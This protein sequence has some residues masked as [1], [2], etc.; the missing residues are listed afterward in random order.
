MLV[1][2]LD[3]VPVFYVLLD[4]ARA[5]LDLTRSVLEL[6]V[7]EHERKATKISLKLL[8]PDFT[9]RARLEHGVQ[10]TVRWGYV[11]ALSAPRAGI[12]HKAEPSYDEGV[13]AVE[14]Y[15]RELS[16]STGAIRAQFRG[17]TL[18]D[19]VTSLAQRAGLRVD[20]QA[21]DTIR[22]D[23]QV[24]DDESAWGWI[25]RRS[26]ELGLIVSVDGDQ[27]VVREPPVDRDAR[28][29]LLWG[30]RNANLLKFEVEE[31]Q[32][33]GESDDEGV[34]AI[35]HDPASGAVLSHAAGAPN[36]TRRTLAAR[37]L[38]AQRRVGASSEA[39][40]IAAYVREHPALATASAA[41]Q[42]DA[43]RADASR[44]GAAGARPTEDS[45]GFLSVLLD[46]GETRAETPARSTAPATTT[47]AGSGAA[48][49]GS[50]ATGTTNAGGRLASTQVPAERSAA[51]AHLQRMAEGGVRRHERG[52]VKAKGTSLG[53]PSA[54]RCDVVRV[55]GVAERDAGLWYAEGVVHKIGES[56]YTTEWELKRD[57]VN[58]RGRGARNRGAAAQNGGAAAGAQGNAAGGRPAD[59]TVVVNLD[60]EGR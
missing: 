34:V 33:K 60:R 17:A 42:R 25:Q 29:L 21:A 6:E 32:K 41:A 31:D 37:R 3:T 36:V 2:I 23:G 28:H 8:D 24:V 54:A 50:G 7:D 59:P 10:I 55:M 39:T 20:W 58:G 40:A 38:A 16:L 57:G 52:K 11:G 44:Q 47:P 5:P 48:T 53:I 30:W 56:G 15:G 14:A 26:A 13:L 19:A 49:S 43:W 18:R 12:V 27:V 46:S 35:F 51:R 9:L 22:F 45:P 1:G 4:N